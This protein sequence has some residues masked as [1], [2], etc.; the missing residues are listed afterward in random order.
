MASKDDEIKMQFSTKY[1]SPQ[2]FNDD[3]AADK[4]CRDINLKIKIS[5]KSEFS[6]FENSLFV[7]L[8][9]QHDFVFELLFLELGLKQVMQLCIHL[10]RNAQMLFKQNIFDQFAGYSSYTCNQ[11]KY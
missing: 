5:G 6:H 10:I 11:T 8:F 4:A 2:R 1:L 3:P 9:N 7:T